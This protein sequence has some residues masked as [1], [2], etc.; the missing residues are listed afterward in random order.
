M[1]I[2]SVLNQLMSALQV[3]DVEDV[4]EYVCWVSKMLAEAPYK[5]KTAL[6]HTMPVLVYTELSAPSAA[7]SKRQRG[8][9]A[10]WVNYLMQIQGTWSVCVCVCVNVCVCVCVCVCV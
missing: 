10:M 1:R 8:G 7:G 6:S 3:D 9:S 2:N 5:A 4:A